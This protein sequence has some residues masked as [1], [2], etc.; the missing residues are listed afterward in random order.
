MKKHGFTLIELLAVSVILTVIAF[1]TVPIIL[2]IIN[3]VKVEADKRSVDHY[4]RSVELALSNYN[5]EEDFDPEE[6]KV[7][8]DGNI[9][10][11]GVTI[12]VEVKGDHPDSG[13]I[14]LQD[15]DVDQYKVY[16]KGVEY[17]TMKYTPEECFIV[18]DNGDGTGTMT[19]Y[20]CGGTRYYNSETR[21]YESTEGKY[22]D[23]VIPEKVHIKEIA[24]ASFSRKKC[25][26]YQTGTGD[27]E[28]EAISQCD[29]LAEQVKDLSKEDLVSNILNQLLDIEYIFT[30][31]MIT[32]TTIEHRDKVV[33]Y[34]AVV[35][36]NHYTVN[37]VVIPDSVTTLGYGA[38]SLC[39]IKK[40]KIPDS[41]TSIGRYAFDGN[42]LEKVTIPSSVTTI[43]ESAFRNNKLTSLTLS[44]GIT[45]IG[46]YA[47]ASNKLTNLTLPES[48]TT[49]DYS[50]FSYN[51][52][53]SVTLPEKITAIGDYAFHYNQLTS[54]TIPSSV[55]TIGK[56][57]F[58][59]NQLTSII[60]P[61]N[62]TKIGELAFDDNQLTQVE[63]YAPKDQVDYYSSSFGW[64][65]GYSNS[66]IQWMNQ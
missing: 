41:V 58:H 26:S 27:T 5:L 63:I 12:E 66:N 9:I 25:I 4:L 8:S 57:A 28:E 18:E 16:L 48:I 50:A 40:V 20:T 60:I 49:I 43:D 31:K 7:Q 30:D 38:F 13:K 44:E 33:P 39:L 3:S 21:E 62:V 64:A 11:D 51:Q 32:I 6:C 59:H 35:P 37:S 2:R 55:I 10:C 47:F 17:S 1:I 29:E 52:L 22:M 23:M 53:I 42:H 56:Y 65:S 46:D 14:L 61:R 15:C 24:S 36:D 34:V 45:T 19:G 54:I